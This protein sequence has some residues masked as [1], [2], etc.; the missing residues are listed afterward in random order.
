MGCLYRITYFLLFIPVILCFARM[1][2]GLRMAGAAA[3]AAAVSLGCYLLTSAVT[4]PYT[5]GFLYHLMRAPDA[6]TFVQMLLSHTKSNLM[7]CFVNT[8]GAPME[9]AF[10]WLYLGTAALCL[11]GTF[12]R[13][14]AR[15]GRPAPEEGAFS[16]GCWGALRCWRRRLR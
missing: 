11:A 16:R 7:D 1:K 2:P 9:H 10:R 14:G 3:V 15:R 13:S 6:G 8:M 12:V 5:Q 4:A